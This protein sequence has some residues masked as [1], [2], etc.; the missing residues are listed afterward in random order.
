MQNAA[1][2]A[3]ICIKCQCHAPIQNNI[4]GTNENS[5]IILRVTVRVLGN[6]APPLSLHSPALKRL[7]HSSSSHIRCGHL[8]SSALPGSWGHRTT[9]CLPSL[10]L[11]HSTKALSALLHISSYRSSSLPDP[12]LCGLL[13]PNSSWPLV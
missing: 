4:W 5:S 9:I 3:H 7:V 13:L 6:C 1:I 12:I 11:H 8:A 10:Y 2:L